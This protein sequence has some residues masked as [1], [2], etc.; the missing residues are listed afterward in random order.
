MHTKVLFRAAQAMNRAGFDVV[1]F[2]FRG[3]GTSTGSY[4]RGFGEQEDAR[5]A[6][7]WLQERSPGLPL[8]LGGFSFGSRV[9]LQVGV[10]E[11][12]VKGLLAIGLAVQNW[13][14]ECL[15]QVA[16]PTLVVQG[17][18]DEFGRGEEVARTIEDAGVGAH[19]TLKRI[20]GSGHFFHDRFDEL[21]EAITEYFASGP[22][23]AA[24]P[25][26]A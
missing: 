25:G 26:V 8:L 11:E 21:Q 17:E 5:A 6:L 3:V 7:D 14:Y 15:R 16:K 13:E 2:N 9:A 23:A 24:F 4:D 1:R 10:E 22:G 12:R 19:V 20:P 18:E